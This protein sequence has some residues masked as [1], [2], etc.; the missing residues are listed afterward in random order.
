MSA[1]NGTN[2]NGASRILTLSDVGR[3]DKDEHGRLYRHNCT[4][5]DAHQIAVEEAQKVHEFY[6][7]QIP[8][9]V[10]RMLQD[11]LIAY[12]LVPNPV[13]PEGTAPENAA[14]EG[15]NAPSPDVLGSAIPTA[16]PDA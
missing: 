2:G 13:P 4:V 10:A 14:P 11:G 7:R 6:L 1:G 9:F 15:S 16:P 5:M 3:N 12:G 8:N